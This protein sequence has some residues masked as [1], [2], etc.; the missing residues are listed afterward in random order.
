MGLLNGQ[1][2]PCAL[3][4]ELCLY[5]ALLYFFFFSFFF[6]FL[7]HCFPFFFLPPGRC[8]FFFFFFF[9]WTLPSFFFFSF[10]LLGKLR[11]V[12]I[13][14]ILFPFAFFCVFFC[15]HF[16]V[17]IGHHFKQW[18]ISKFIQTHF[19]YFS[20]FSLPTKQ[21]WGK[22]KF[23]L[24]SHFLI[25]LPF[26]ILPLF[27]PSNQMFPKFWLTKCSLFFF[28]LEKKNTKFMHIF[29]LDVIEFHN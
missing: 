14:H 13:A 7:G 11:P 25:L 17:L 9:P 1:K 29:L 12:Y 21:K 22:L 15:C 6:I 23:F 26:S 10:D 8:L 2:Y 16:L 5:I 27:Y 3:A 28:F 20:T 4:H 19:F 24:S 18:Y